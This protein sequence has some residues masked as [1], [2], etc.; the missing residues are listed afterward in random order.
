MGGRGFVAEC[1]AGA[2]ELAKVRIEIEGRKGRAS[3][4]GEV[5][6]RSDDGE[7][8]AIRKREDSRPL[9]VALRAPALPRESLSIRPAHN[10]K[11]A[12]LWIMWYIRYIE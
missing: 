5:A 12:K 7:G 9:S 3:P 2:E 10:S 4:W 6:S 1:G 11:L 8:L